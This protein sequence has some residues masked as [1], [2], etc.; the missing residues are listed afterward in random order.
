MIGLLGTDIQK[1]GSVFIVR[2]NDELCQLIALEGTDYA[3]LYY[4]SPDQIEDLEVRKL[5]KETK[6]KFEE[7]LEALKFDEYIDNLEI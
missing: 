6:A 2:T 1:N 3:I 7:L 4:L 5:W